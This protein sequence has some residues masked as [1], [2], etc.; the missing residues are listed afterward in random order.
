MNHPKATLLTLEQL[1]DEFTDDQL[2]AVVKA[3]NR[4]RTLGCGDIVDTENADAG[5]HRQR[6]DEQID[7]GNP[8][9]PR[10]QDSLRRMHD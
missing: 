1:N 2:T 7:P 5:V 3:A 8:A 4:L 10:P 9:R 6:G